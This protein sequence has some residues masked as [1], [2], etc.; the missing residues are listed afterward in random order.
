VD[1]AIIQYQEALALKPDYAEAHNNLGAA[2]FKTA[3]G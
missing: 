3:N 1:E 2:F